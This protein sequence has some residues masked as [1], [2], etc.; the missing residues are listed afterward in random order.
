MSLREELD[1]LPADALDEFMRYGR[2]A[3]YQAGEW[4]PGSG[5]GFSGIRLIEDG[6]V[7]IYAEEEGGRVHLCRSGKDDFIGVRSM[8]SPKSL[9]AIAWQAE[10]D[11]TCLEFDQHEVLQ[12]LQSRDGFELRQV[13]ERAA[14]ER[15]YDV[16]MALHP[17][18]RSLPRDERNT[19]L[20]SAHPIALLPDEPL[21]RQNIEND[22]L[23]LISRG[24]VEIRRTGE[25]LAVRETGEV[26]GEISV[27]GSSDTATAD[28]IS[29]GWCEVLAFPGALIRGYSEANAQF[30]RELIRLR[31]SSGF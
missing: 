23:Y 2:T 3:L 25:L 4:L 14:R 10:S 6:V 26:I 9:P 15:D 28:V 8:F 5:S 20:R 21:L 12:L 24:Q 1:L 16:L 19:L 13:L 30:E 29:R 27:L 31:H 17:L 7:S 11:V 22:T 18:F